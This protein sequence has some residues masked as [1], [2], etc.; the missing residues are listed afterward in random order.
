MT[1]GFTASEQSCQF[2]D[3]FFFFRFSRTL[4][5][6][7]GHICISSAGGDAGKLAFPLQESAYLNMA[8]I[9]GNS[10]CFYCYQQDFWRRLC[11]RILRLISSQY[12]VAL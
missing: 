9:L 4:I 8:S 1:S 7:C 10:L 11:L 6:P 2:L 3:F 12:L 5:Q